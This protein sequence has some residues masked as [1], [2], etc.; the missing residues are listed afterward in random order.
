MSESLLTKLFVFILFSLH[1]EAKNLYLSERVTQVKTK[2]IKTTSS[3]RII[4][5]AIVFT[6][7]AEG[8]YQIIV[9]KYKKGEE[10]AKTEVQLTKRTSI[11]NIEGFKE[12]INKVAAHAKDAT[13]GCCEPMNL[14]WNNN[15]ELHFE[16]FYKN[17][18]PEFAHEDIHHF[19]CESSSLDQYKLTFKCKKL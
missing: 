4:F 10:G 13:Y 2:V 8:S 7:G 11:I 3:G 17:P 1:V 6:E 18:L 5:R 19:H 12:L 15:N 9:E 14:T 16:L